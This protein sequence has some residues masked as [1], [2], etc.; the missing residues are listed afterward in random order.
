[1]A[2]ITRQE[3]EAKGFVRVRVSE[4][5]Q[6]F[7]P[8]AAEGCCRLDPGPVDY[9]PPVESR[10]GDAELNRSYPLELV[11]SK[12]HDSM[13]STFGFRP[14]VDAQTARLHMHPDDAAPR[15]IAQDDL[16]RVFNG[17]GECLLTVSLGDTVRPGVVR[18]PSVRWA[19]NSPRGRNVNALTSDRLTDLGGGA[20]FYSCLVQVERCAD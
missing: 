15:G 6:P 3:L 12:N 13:N 7:Q 5:D 19:R 16:V 18:A 17:R 11:S 4:E 1:V 2:G 9:A 14:E 20:T 8:Y 10:L